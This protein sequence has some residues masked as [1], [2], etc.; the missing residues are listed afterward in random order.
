MILST[1][2]K[3]TL[4]F[5]IVINAPATTVW[6]R[7]LTQETYREWTSAFEPTSYY[8][9]SWEKGSRMLFLSSRGG[10]MVATIAENIPHKFISIQHVGQIQDGVEDTTSDAV[11]SWLPAF[12]NYTFT[13]HDGS[14]LLSIDL[15][16]TSTPESKQMKE[17]FEGMWPAALAKLKEICER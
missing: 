11:T 7:M 6:E 16:M 9:G 14:T 17:M 4:H 12:E 10:G 3:E 2:M 8:E 1:H 15:E 5:D 13:E